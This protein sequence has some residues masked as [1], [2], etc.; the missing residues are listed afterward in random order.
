MIIRE[1]I[2][3]TEKPFYIEKVNGYS[4]IYDNEFQKNLSNYIGNMYGLRNIRDSIVYLSEETSTPISD[5]IKSY[6]ESIYISKE[7]EYK[8]LFNTLSVEY[9]PIENYS[10]EE[11]ESN[12]NTTNQNGSNKIGEQNTINNYGARNITENNGEQTSINTKKVAPFDSEEFKNNE[13]ENISVNQFTKSSTSNSYADNITNGERNDT[14]TLTE[15]EQNA[16][17]LTRKGNIGVTTSQQ[18]IMSEREVANFEFMRIVA[19]DIVN[20]ITIG[21]W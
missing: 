17:T 6:C 1:Y 16:R 20:N 8:K 3:Q 7:Y 12:E 10:M 4:P 9:N 18:M 13:Q 21:V 15:T 2:K 5:V 11:I 14:H 19:K